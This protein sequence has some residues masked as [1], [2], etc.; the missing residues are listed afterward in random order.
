[1]FYVLEVKN[2]QVLV[3]CYFAMTFG[4][5]FF[6]LGHS[7]QKVLLGQEFSGMSCLKDILS[8]GQKPRQGRGWGIQPPPPQGLRG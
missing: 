2:N 3:I 8:Q 6:S 5:Y 7:Q 1:M 4:C